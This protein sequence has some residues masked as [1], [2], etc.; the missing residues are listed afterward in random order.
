M[1]VSLALT[2]TLCTAL[3][4]SGSPSRLNCPSSTASTTVRKHRYGSG[5]GTKR[6]C[7][8]ALSHQLLL[9][10]QTVRSVL[11]VVLD[12]L[13]V[14]PQSLAEPTMSPI[15]T[16]SDN[17]GISTSTVIKGFTTSDD[18]AIKVHV[19]APLAEPQAGSGTTRSTDNSL[20]RSDRT[21]ETNRKRT[22]GT[23][24]IK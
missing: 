7:L 13:T 9:A 8:T 5:H 4:P 17:H 20:Q 15:S 11:T 2:D 21:K 24:N 12:H 23:E 22:M 19:T 16:T 18:Q 1:T 3:S 14:E 6:D 10:G